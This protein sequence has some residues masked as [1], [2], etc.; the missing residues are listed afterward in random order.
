MKWRD[1]LSKL[2]PPPQP[3]VVRGA[4]GLILRPERSPHGWMKVDYPGSMLRNLRVSEPLHNRKFPVRCMTDMPFE[5]EKLPP[6]LFH[7]KA[8]VASKVIR[9][10]NYIDVYPQSIA[11]EIRDKL[12]D[13]LHK[14]VYVEVASCLF[15]NDP[16]LQTVELDFTGPRARYAREASELGGYVIQ[17]SEIVPPP[18]PALTT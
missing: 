17:R 10:V 8:R 4:S 2:T 12:E 1:A 3:P 13:R 7:F 14:W 9:A 11:I 15:N 16:D 6:H 18:N 5:Q